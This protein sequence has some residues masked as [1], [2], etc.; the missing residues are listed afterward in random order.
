MEYY[1]IKIKYLDVLNS[2]IKRS[3]I[4]K[5]FPYRSIDNS[6]GCTPNVII[7]TSKYS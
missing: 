7:E 3:E 1:Y 2:M 4:E 5:E 6:Y